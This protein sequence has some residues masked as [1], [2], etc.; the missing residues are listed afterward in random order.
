MKDI[1]KLDWKKVSTN[2]PPKDG[3]TILAAHYFEPNETLMW[4]ASIWYDDVDEVWNCEFT[5]EKFN[6]TFFHEFNYWTKLK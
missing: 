1:L 4:V 6:N 2:T 5:D 3:E